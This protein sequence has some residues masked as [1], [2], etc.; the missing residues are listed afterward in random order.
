MPVFKLIAH[1]STNR[2]YR[3]LAQE[4]NEALIDVLA[5]VKI[6]DGHLDPAEREEL[7]EGMSKLDWKGGEGLES[8]LDSAVDRARSLSVYDG[9]LGGFFQNVSDRLGED[10]LRQ[11]AYYIASRISLADQKV[12]EEEREYLQAMVQA[13]GIDAKTQALIIRKIRNEIDF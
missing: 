13:F 12:V 1:I 10:W 11:E 3:N 2:R 4:Q 7:L 6:I 9:S 8:Y 5:A